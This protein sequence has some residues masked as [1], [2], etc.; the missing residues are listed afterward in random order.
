M[1]AGPSTEISKQTQ[2]EKYLQHGETHDDLVRRLASTL[3]DN[4]VHEREIYKIFGAQKFLPA[5][6]IQSAVGSKRDVT[7]INCYVS[8]NIEDSFEGIMRAATNAGRTMRMGG[9]IGYDFSTLRPRGDLIK[10]LDSKSSGPISFMEIFNSVCQTIRSAGHRRG[11]QMGVIRVDHPDIEEFIETKTDL[12]RLTGFNVSVAITDGFMRAVKSDTTFDLQFDGKIYKTVFAR[13]LWN[14]IMQTTWD[15][16]EPG[17]IFIDRINEYNN[18]WYCEEINT[19]NPCGEQPLPPFGA[20]LLGSF[21]WTKYV[22]VNSKTFDYDQFACDIP[23]V[24]RAMDN[25]IDNTIYPLPEQER[26]EKSKRRMGLGPTGVANALEF[27]GLPYGS[28][29]YIAEQSRIM[30]IL[31]DCAYS[32][33]VDLAIEKGPFELFDAEKYCA[34]PFVKTLPQ[35]LQDRIAKHGIRN[36]HLL[37][38]APT[39]TISL[40][41]DNVSSSIEPVFSLYYDRTIQGFD[42]ATVERVYD[43]GYKF[44]DH[45]GI[46]ADKVTTNQHVDVLAAAQRYVDS[47]CS[48]T[49]NVGA[50]VTFDEFKEI[51]MRAYDSGAKGCTTFRAAGKR[52]GV[53]NAP[54]EEEPQGES[55]TFD[56]QTGK[57]TCE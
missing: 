42:G 27:M 29:E 33:S 15:Y 24:V 32:A 51:Y 30:E 18:L 36:S 3:A 48:K 45:K 11:A 5:G 46:T 56:P 35:H 43:Y 2:Q 40:C 57:K 9:G 20:C 19:T 37:S 34:S 16:A 23:L 52:F 7:A 22:D 26:E 14:K 55:C 38:V 4:A 21:N 47:A 1:F 54:V 12:T 44:F 39:G 28:P 53:L 25:V 8:E 49:C 6:R 41:A 50:E 17:V 10:S 31:R 13:D